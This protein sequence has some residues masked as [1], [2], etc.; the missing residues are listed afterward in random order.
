MSKNFVLDTNVLLTDPRCIVEGFEENN[1]V[2]PLAVIEEVD[3]IKKEPQN[4]GY[5]AR[6]V[7]RVLDQLI[8]DNETKNI[9]KGIKR[10]DLGGVISVV[11]L[12]EEDIKELNDFNFSMDKKD[13]MIVLTALKCTKEKEGKTI[14]VSN[15]TNARLKAIIHDL[16]TE[17]YK[18]SAIPKEVVD[19]KG[20]RTLKL[21]LSFF[22]SDVG[23]KFE[24]REHQDVLY[25]DDV[26][27]EEGEIAPNE[28]VLLEADP[29]GV[30]ADELSSRD[31]KKLKKVY[32]YMD[33][34]LMHRDLKFKNLFGNIVGKNLEQS[35]G[36][37]ILMSDDIKVVTLSSPAGTGKTFLSLACALTKLLEKNSKYEKIILVKP[38]VSVANEMGFLPGDVH[39]KLEPYMKSYIDNFETLRKMHHEGY[40]ETTRTF[41]EMIE[42]GQIEI[43][44]ISYIRGRSFQDCIIIVD[45]MQNVG[46]DVVKTILS[47]VGQNTLTICSGDPSQIDVSYLSKNNNGLSHLIR[48]FRGQEFFGHVSFVKCERSIVAEKS[49]ELL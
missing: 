19:Y 49:A 48:K 10:N 1:L 33:G 4:R 11:S 18:N 6:E 27:L 29:D 41:E 9:R 24:K 43:E 3:G 20:Y 45:E 7:F 16:P 40:K 32:R 42:D 38:V 47:R 5:Q 39:S 46:S 17:I 35:V 44:A 36:M 34:V 15:D 2:I 21:P 26:G 28:F 8:F 14:F 31:L 12:N 25:L 13:D 30:N 23:G 37:D 22:G